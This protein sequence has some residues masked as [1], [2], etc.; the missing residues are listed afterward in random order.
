M[1]TVVLLVA[2]LVLFSIPSLAGEYLMNDTGK[3]V[4]RLRVV[5]SERV[6]LTGF[7]DVLTTVEPTGESREFTFSG[8]ELEAWGGHW[9]RWEPASA[10]VISHEWIF[11]EPSASIFSRNYKMEL[12]EVFDEQELDSEL[13]TMIGTDPH[14]A[15]E[16]VDGM[17]RLSGTPS[18]SGEAQTG[19]STA[20]CFDATA[21]FEVVA[22]VRVIARQSPVIVEVNSCNSYQHLTLACHDMGY[23]YWWC[24]APEACEEASGSP[25][26]PRG[27]LYGTATLRLTYDGL[28]HAVTASVDGRLV[29]TG[30]LADGFHEVVVRVFV[31]SGARHGAVGFVEARVH[32]LHLGWGG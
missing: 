32:E 8:G 31:Q 30:V 24:T 19:I 29:G 4:Y 18:R 10:R 3:A 22:L 26:L 6:T 28:T 16:L 5:F 17:L 15:V 21:G 20:E 13:W 23:G 14:V 1:K 7:G 27:S 12:H 11:G 2:V 25:L 9:F